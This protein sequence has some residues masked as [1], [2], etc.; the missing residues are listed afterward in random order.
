MAL[1]PNDHSLFGLFTFLDGNPQRTAAM[2]EKGYVAWWTDL[3]SK[4]QFWRPVSE[5]SHWLDYQLW[6]DSPFLMHAQSI[7]C[8]VILLSVLAMFYRRFMAG[9]VA[10]LAL[11]LYAID[12]DHGLTVSWISNRNAILATTFGLLALWLHDKWRRDH[13]SHGQWLGPIFLLLALFSAE[14]AIGMGDYLLAYTIFID[15]SSWKSRMMAMLP[16]GIITVLWRITYNTL[17]Y[18]SFASSI[19]FDPGRDLVGFLEA[20]LSRFPVLLAGQWGF[21][22]ADI[23]NIFGGLAA[24]L[25]VL[26]ALLFILALLWIAL[27]TL[28]NSKEARFF[29]CGMLLSILP[30]CAPAPSSRLLLFTGVG[31][32]GLMALMLSQWLEKMH[33]INGIKRYVKNSLFGL[34]IFTHLLAAPILLPMV[35]WL[36]VILLADSIND[37]AYVIPIDKQDQ[38]KTLVF[39]NPPVAHGATIIPLMRERAGL[40]N[41]QTTYLL[42]SNTPLLTVTRS[43]EYTL[44]LQSDQGIYHLVSDEVNLDASIGFKVGEIR[45]FKGMQVLIN[46]I[47]ADGRP[48]D[49]DVRFKQKLINEDLIFVRWSQDKGLERLSGNAFPVKKETK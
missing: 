38:E 7:F 25:Y 27:P 6:P 24:S 2:V 21:F 22:P 16:Y 37:I 23:F 10:M 41:T 20:A 45:L 8:Y 35:T 47:T 39:I 3:H 30:I 34:L 13:W 4:T 1:T 40:I 26:L 42:A 46:A 31:A 43:D 29:A 44:N 9:S 15:D 36:P 32:M 49:I 11:L 5:I 33:S 12:A 17:G 28:K 14:F 19:Y 48:S 18:G